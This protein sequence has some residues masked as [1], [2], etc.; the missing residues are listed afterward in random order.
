MLA[1]LAVAELLGMSVW[2]AGTVLA[3]A[4]SRSWGLTP[5]ESA[6][7]TSVVPLG[8][9][10]GT[11]TLAVLNIPDTVPSRTLFSVAA[12]AAAA[13]NALLLVASGYG[14]ALLFRFATGACLAGVYPPA[15]KMAATWFRAARGLA[16][17]S[18][19]GALTVGKALPYLFEALGGERIRVVL[20]GTSGAAAVAAALIWLLYRDGPFAFARRPFSWHLAGAVFRDRR[21]RLVTS[22]YLGHMWEL[23]AFWAWIGAY[24][25][26][27]GAKRALL[28]YA[29]PAVTTLRLLTFVTI[30]IGAVGCVYGGRLA[31]RIGRERLVIAA[32]IVSGSCA[33]LS[34][35]VFGASW[36]LVVPLAWV[37][38]IAVVADSAQFSALATELAP[39]HGVG[40]ALTLQTS[41]GFLLTM[42]SI[43]L[44][45]L[46]VAT[47]G[48]RF[49]FPML[50]A[51][52]AFGILAMQRVRAG[53]GATPSVRVATPAGTG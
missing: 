53:D 37:W 44:V 41:L 19:V 43:Q 52:P 13:A 14:T 20:L 9:V 10:A 45:P 8:F 46:V 18:V 12:L 7:I 2:F 5:A 39:A 38:G 29:P 17:G 28:G 11:L 3:P 35:A 4:L 42:A 21:L 16:I 36:W 26:A 22:G 15:M 30:A 49:A 40:T 24:F 47:A 1:L 31:D 6:W 27:S 34:S 48:W 33:M 32:L 51:G 23:Y 25:A 50:A